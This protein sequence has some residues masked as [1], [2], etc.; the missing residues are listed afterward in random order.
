MM[1][2]DDY[3]IYYENI[4]SKRHNDHNHWMQNEKQCL[5]MTISYIVEIYSLDDITTV[6][7][8]FTLK[9]NT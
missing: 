9:N 4:F 1:P 6:M 3:I 2:G 8:E 7:A 5:V